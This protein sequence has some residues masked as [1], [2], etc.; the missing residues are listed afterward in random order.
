MPGETSKCPRAQRGHILTRSPGSRH[1]QRRRHTTA[2]GSIRNARVDGYEVIN[3]DGTPAHLKVADETD[4]FAHYLGIIG[5]EY[6]FYAQGARPWA[7][8]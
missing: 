3:L 4:V 7:E 6:C 5:H 2:R 1:S 8:W